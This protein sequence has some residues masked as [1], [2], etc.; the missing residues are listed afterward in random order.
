MFVKNSHAKLILLFFL[1]LKI[2]FQA[3]DYSFL[4]ETT[5]TTAELHNRG[6]FERALEFNMNALS[7]YE[8]N[9]DKDGIITVYTNI[10]YLL[11]SFGRLKESIIYLDK[12][13][14]EMNNNDNP[15]FQARIYN[16]YA[17]NYTRLGLLKQ[18]NLNFDKAIEYAHKIPDEKQRTYLLFYSYTWKRLN[19]LNQIDSLREIEKKSL[20][21]KI[22]A[23][24]YTKIADRF[25]RAKT[26]LDSAE[27]YLHKAL[28][29]PD[30]NIVAVQGLT[31]FSFGNLYSVKGEHKKALEYYL[32]SLKTFQKVKFRGYVRTAYDS[33]SSTY[34][35]LHDTEKSAEYLKKFKTIN[36]SIKKEE[37]EA[38][39][40]VVEKLLQEEKNQERKQRI[41]FYVLISVIVASSLALIYQ[42][43]KYYLSKQLE[44][45]RLIEK[46]NT[47]SI[48]LK[49]KINAPINEIIQLA[50]SGSPFFL[51]RFKE[52]HSEFYKKL[53]AHCPDL[54]DNE[55]KLCAYIKLDISTK[56]IAFFENVTL[57]TAETKKYRLKKK[58]RLSSDTELKKWIQ[59][60]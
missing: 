42:I 36:D 39:N 7:E 58:L 1:F 34:E 22:S 4:P 51:A 48:K 50:E 5:K 43:R 20:K 13:K 10:A 59:E 54:T 53:T 27:Y 24:T 31:R 55:V 49:E 37:K 26:H 21:I 32:E 35:S 44:K 23:I 28:L 29:A 45:D 30:E 16:E 18:S 56:D 9:N 12:A 2:N 52:A 15:L 3:Q 19:F 38:V 6:E 57:R 11:V 8:K 46:Q 17:K 40:I 25:I 60:L 33:I 14:K 41:K 47:D